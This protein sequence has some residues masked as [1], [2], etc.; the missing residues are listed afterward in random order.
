MSFCIRAIAA[1]ALSSAILSACSPETDPP[2]PP[3]VLAPGMSYAITAID[4]SA[5]PS[6]STLEVGEDGMIGGQG[7]CNRWSGQMTRIDGRLR[8]SSGAATARACIDPARERADA[9]MHA[10]LSRVVAARLTSP[11]GDVA[12]TDENAR[13]L[14]TLIP[15]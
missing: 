4:G 12:L 2:M 9:A 5:A 8:M 11:A 15:R 13:S 14:L 7:P 6:G 10:A 3:K 1:G